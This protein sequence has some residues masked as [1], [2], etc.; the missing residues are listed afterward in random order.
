MPREFELRLQDILKA[1]YTI[2]SIVEG[3]TFDDFIGDQRN[4][5]LGTHGTLERAR[6]LNPARKVM[7]WGWRISP[8]RGDGG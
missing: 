5:D 1:C 8:L 6:L 2:I 4:V 3:I 7:F